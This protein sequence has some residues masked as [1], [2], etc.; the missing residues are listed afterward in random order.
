MLPRLL[1]RS[2]SL[3]PWGC[4]RKG[5]ELAP[6]DFDANERLEFDPY[7]KNAGFYTRGLSP[8]ISDEIKNKS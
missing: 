2:P 1:N 4:D 8:E 6:F 7:P 3:M 5:F